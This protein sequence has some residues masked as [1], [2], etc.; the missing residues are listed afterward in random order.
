LELPKV[1]I[2]RARARMDDRVIA[3]PLANHDLRGLESCATR[4]DKMS[5]DDVE[6]EAVPVLNR[7]RTGVRG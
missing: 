4:S 3:K 6:A 1:A 2:D 5:V 7:C